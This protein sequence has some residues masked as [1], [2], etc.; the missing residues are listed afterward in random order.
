[1]ARF[2]LAL[3][4]RAASKHTGKAGPT[5]RKCYDAAVSGKVPAEFIDNRWTWDDGDLDAIVRG[6]GM[7]PA[8]FGNVGEDAGVRA[9]RAA[10][11]HA[12]V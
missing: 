6:L 10:G 3:M 12:S 11:E 9:S 8:Q 5:Y 7:V 2:G 1:M 4:P